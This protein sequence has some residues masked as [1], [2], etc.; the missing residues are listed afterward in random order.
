MP[1]RTPP[2]FARPMAHAG[3]IHSA[4]RKPRRQGNGGKHFEMLERCLRI[5][6]AFCSDGAHCPAANR[7]L[8]DSRALARC[9]EVTVDLW[10]TVPILRATLIDVSEPTS[11]F[12]L[13]TGICAAIASQRRPSAQ[14]VGLPGFGPTS[15][16]ACFARFGCALASEAGWRWDKLNLRPAGKKSKWAGTNPNVGL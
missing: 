9:A 3:S 12:L 6:P 10:K 16:S 7:K 1:P 5:V 11:S 4:R 13:L 15:N 2:V 14:L 8:N